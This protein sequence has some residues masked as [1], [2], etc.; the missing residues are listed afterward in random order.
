M[1]GG[2][3]HVQ[4]CELDKIKLVKQTWPRTTRTNTI[5]RLQNRIKKGKVM[6]PFRIHCRTQKHTEKKNPQRSTS[7]MI[8]IDYNR[9]V[10][11]VGGKLYKILNHTFQKARNMTETNT[12]FGG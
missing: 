1:D 8:Q 9:W 7:C 11:F 2:K 10:N 3:R 5:S 12:K 6:L 4:N